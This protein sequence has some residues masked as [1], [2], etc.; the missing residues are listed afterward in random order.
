[1]QQIEHALHVHLTM[2]ASPLP[3][4]I[5]AQTDYQ[6]GNQKT[7]VQRLEVLVVKGVNKVSSSS[8]TV[9]IFFTCN[10]NIIFTCNTV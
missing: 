1:M 8:L 10:N 6:G 4:V 3:Q 9:I 7:S 2:Q 5:A